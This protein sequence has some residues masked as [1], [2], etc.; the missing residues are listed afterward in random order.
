[1]KI[2]GSGFDVVSGGIV[3]DPFLDRISYLEHKPERIFTS[4]PSF[5]DRVIQW[6]V[7]GSGTATIT[8]DSQKTQNQEKV[9]KF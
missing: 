6:V 9:V 1:M 5:G 2:E 3:R 4:V 7:R 8:F